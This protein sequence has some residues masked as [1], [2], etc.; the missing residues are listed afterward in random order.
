MPPGRLGVLTLATDDGVH[1]HAFVSGPGPDVSLQLVGPAAD[2][3]IGLDPLAIGAIWHEF[4]ARSRM[5][6]PTVQGYIDIAL[7]DIAGKVAGLP[8]HRLLGS[9]RTRLPAYVSSW[10]HPDN[11]TYVEEALAYRD[12]G[13]P[14]YKLH[15]PTQRRRMPVSGRNEAVAI[16]EDMST[17]AAVREA[18]GPGYPLMLDAAWAYTYREAVS[19]GFAIQDLDY[20]WYEDPLGAEDIHGYVRLKQHLHIPVVATEITRGGLHALPAWIEAHA[21]DALRGDVVI[22]G[23]IT[24]MMKIGALAEAYHLPCEVHDAYNAIGNLATVHVVMAL[25]G[26]SM[27]EVLV[28]HAPGS[29][30]LDHL[31][32]GLVE[33]IAIDEDGFVLAPETAGLGIDVDWELIRSNVVAEL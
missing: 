5:F 18:L 28:P 27:Y 30:D 26:C 21:T 3:L 24:G 4:S 6:D 29:Y 7:W 13:F 15:P 16:E 23:G 17:C 12:R 8:V 31:S 22:K 11:Q 10:V 32:Y 20:L 33:P 19:V 2:L 9:C 14:A 1:G 25:H